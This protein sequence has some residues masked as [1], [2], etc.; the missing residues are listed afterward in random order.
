MVLKSIFLKLLKISVRTTSRLEFSM[1]R[2]HAEINTKSS[3]NILGNIHGLI[4]NNK[5]LFILFTI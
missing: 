1:N 4:V 5:I 3:H 2:I